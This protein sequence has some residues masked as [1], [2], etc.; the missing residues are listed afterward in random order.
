M[1]TSPHP[2]SQ[3][4]SAPRRNFPATK[5]SPH[6]ESESET[7]HKGG[8]LVHPTQTS[9]DEI[10]RDS[11]EQGRKAGA[12]KSSNT[13]GGIMVHSDQ[14]CR[15]T[16]QISLLKKLLASTAATDPCRFHQLGPNRYSRSLTPATRVSFPT[17]S[18][19]SLLEPAQAF[20]TAQVQDASLDPYG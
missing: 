2:Q 11:W 8:I 19:L 12:A 14:L 18:P 7:L 20:A 3:H 15:Q 9:K 6:Q 4:C 17:C 1:P 16:Q 5:T 13:A 10:Y